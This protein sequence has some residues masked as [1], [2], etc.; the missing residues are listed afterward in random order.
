V[1]GPAHM[2]RKTSTQL[3]KEGALTTEVQ[4]SGIPPQALSNSIGMMSSSGSKPKTQRDGGFL[5]KMLGSSERC[6]GF[7]ERCWVPLKDGGL[8]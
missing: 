3:Q 4:A 1:H 2:N 5:G 7:S 6:W 8:L